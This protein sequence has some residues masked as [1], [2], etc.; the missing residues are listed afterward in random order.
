VR[1][2]LSNDPISAL[3]APENRT[4]PYSLYSRIRQE[5]PIFWHEP[6]QSWF[7]TRYDDAVEV[8]RDS[9]LF[10]SDWRRAGEDV[11]PQFISV[12]T[13]DPPE[14]AIVRRPLMEAL[15]TVDGPGFDS[16]VTARS[17]ELLAGLAGRASFDLV[18]DFAEP[19]TLS[20]TM[21]LLGV[22]EP[23]LGW[24]V[25]VADAIVDGMDAGLWPERAAAAASAKAELSEH[26]AGWLADP[27]SRG[28]VGHLARH[29]GTG[30]GGGGGIEPA[31]LA[32]T[33]R[34]LLHA[35]YT[36]AS[37][38][39]T[40]AAAALLALPGGVSRFPV[41]PRAAAT[42]VDEL[43]R[44]TSPVQAVARAC[45]LDCELAGARVRTGDGMTVLVGAANRDPD[46]FPDPDDLRLDRAPNPH[47]GFGRGPH[48]CLGS[49]V[50]TR[51]A[52]AV[53]SLLARRHPD[54]RPTDLPRYRPNV[55]LRGLS[56]L[57]VTVG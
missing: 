32:N 34:V 47:L 42:A 16:F 15:R 56:R 2:T 7:V 46:R 25:P 51:Q 9:S 54:L 36:S 5:R 38:F 35:G 27:P 3:I 12:Q 45:V 39:L 20:T 57:E 14:H 31:V 37:K 40:L 18:T 44:F 50:A 30:T 17:T 8:L 21:W 52:R 1:R 23:D 29:T 43:A 24:F 33:V 10:G 13:L 49:V 53:F 55:T 28:M 26:I 4:D 22:P 11:P 41:D 19:L 48:S 6:L